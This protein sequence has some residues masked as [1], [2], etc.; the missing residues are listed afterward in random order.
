MALRHDGMIDVELDDEPDPSSRPSAQGGGPDGRP[1]ARREPL[2]PALRRVR[3]RRGLRATAV[4][5]TVSG[6]ALGGLTLRDTAAVRADDARVRA[7]ADVPGLVGSLRTPLSERWRGPAS[8]TVAG[9][10]ALTA[11]TVDGTV[12]TVARDTST[13][14]SR[15]LVP[16]S[17]TPA[18]QPPTCAL[19]APATALT[20]ELPGR[21]GIPSP[22]T[23]ETLG[24]TP[25]RLITFD[26]A[27]GAVLDLEVLPVATVGWAV[28]GSDVVTA[29]LADGALVVTRTAPA[30]RQDVWSR[31]VRLPV[32]VIARQL[33]LRVT[34]GLVEV[35]GA[36]AAVLDATTGTTLGTFA[37][38]G[39]DSIAVQLSADRL[40]FTTWQGGTGTWYDRR[41]HAGTSLAGTPLEPT[42]DDGSSATLLLRGDAFA[43]GV[44]ILD[45][46]PRWTLTPVRQALLRLRGLLLLDGGE[47]LRA[48]DAE[49]GATRWSAAAMA[50][51]ADAIVPCDGVR[52]LAVVPGHGRGPAMLTAF[53]L[54]DGSVAWSVPMPAGTTTLAARD[55]AVVATGPEATVVLG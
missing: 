23:D 17:L 22:N 44:D 26:A 10:L 18:N 50:S 40:G 2:T 32:P 27:T 37:P 54:D 45:G 20:C 30:T 25:S 47:M 43:Y 15:W 9:P 52:V 33:D 8:A 4:V 55:G 13:G 35:D 16:R 53:V 39:P 48:V 29:S 41:G 42:I 12:R 1:P 31:R 38:D 21:P 51:E 11:E 49:T 28:A 24:G 34:K 6:L 5:L 14:A 3:R 7:L 36:I 19:L 46:S